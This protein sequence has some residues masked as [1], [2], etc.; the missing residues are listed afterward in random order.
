MFVD[1]R[2]LA[3]E[4]TIETGICIIGAGAAGITLAHEIAGHRLDACVVESG[5]LDLEAATQSLYEAESVGLPYFPLDAN[6]QRSF[7]GTTALWAGWCRPLD[8]LD[9][10]S[11]P[12]VP[13]SGWPISSRELLPYYRRAH[14]LCDLPPCE[15]RPADW[16]LPPGTLPLP[17][18]HIIT[19]IF[20]LS[21]PTRFGQKYREA[22]SQ[23]DSVQVLLHANAMALDANDTATAVMRL[24]VGCLSGNRFSVRAR[25]YVLAAGG[26]ENARLLLL[27][28][29]VQ[30]SGLGN[31]RDNVGR[32]FM[33]HMHFPAAT[34]ALS[35]EH[36]RAVAAYARGTEGARPRLALA[37]AVQAQE[38]LLNH[39]VML[40]PVHP[41]DRLV[42]ALARRIARRAHPLRDRLPPAFDPGIAP[43]LGVLGSFT[44]RRA[45]RR[46]RLHLT[47]EQAPNR[48][49]RVTL[50][51]QRDALEMPR[52][53]LAWRT[54]PLD[55]RTAEMAPQLVGAAFARAGI[56]QLLLDSVADS[57][58][59][60]P[61][62]LQGLRGHHMG[63]T[64]M[65][66]DA[67]H[68]VV[69]SQ[70]RVHG[71]ANLFIAGSSVF[72]TAGAGAPTLT[73][74]ALALR[75]ADHLRLL[76]S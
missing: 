32:Y 13:L 17:G 3:A 36:G 53:R 24:R 67:R 57:N 2:R 76:G 45:A 23:A 73:I 12:W 41:Y 39:S 27:S 15:Y 4:S 14:L 59:W 75:L 66:P 46:W 64:R 38:Q 25:H 61:P 52:G 30:P 60:P 70:C 9:L 50:T 10:E 69:D 48:E 58:R 47:M 42:A 62:P 63:T 37:P 20:R 55:Q 21:P 71:I 51:S 6:R 16:E 72:P 74:V 18:E 34:L 65:S 1:A 19:K 54:T 56:G 40:T 26:I 22:L 8:D 31:E 28:D 35:S 5:A 33:E 68:G 11:R 29:G 43:G 7:G 49:S 44:S